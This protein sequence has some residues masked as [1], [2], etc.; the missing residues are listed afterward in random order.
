MKHIILSALLITICGICYSQTV[1]VYNSGGLPILYGT[2]ENSAETAQKYKN[3]EINLG[4]A[5]DAYEAGD[6]AKTKYY[7]D[8]SEKKGVISP[9]FYFLLGQ[10]FYVK[11]EYKYARRYWKRGYNRGC[12]ECN[13]KIATI[14]DKWYNNSGLAQQHT[15]KSISH[16]SFY[17]YF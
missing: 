6:L 2:K 10:Y 3:A 13:E 9:G 4:K 1:I 5:Y 8:Q 17:V 15:T 16:L 14:P 12:Y 11:K 7:L